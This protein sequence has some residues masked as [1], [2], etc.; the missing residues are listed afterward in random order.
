MS[1]ERDA[2]SM[3]PQGKFSRYRSVRQPPA[4]AYPPPVEVMPDNSNAMG[5]TKSMSRYRRSRIGSPELSNDTPPPLPA[6]PGGNQ[7][8]FAVSSGNQRVRRV[9]DPASSATR[10]QPSHPVERG[11]LKS[12][13]AGHKETEDER[14]RRKVKEFREREARNARAE[15]QKASDDGQFARRKNQAAQIAKQRKAE[16]EAQAE[17]IRAQEE[18]T[19]RLLAEQKRKDLERLEATLDAAGPRPPSVTSPKDKFNFFSRKRATSKVAPPRTSRS[20]S[21]SGSGTLSATRTRSIEAPPK[22]LK[23]AR[24]ASPPSR[25]VVREPHRLDQP[26]APEQMIQEGGGGIVPQTD[27]PISASN[28][29]ERRV[30][31]RCKQSSINLPVTPETTPVDLIYSAANIMTQNIIPS[32]AIILESYK[33]LGLERRIRRYEHIRDVMNSWD[34]DTQNSLTIANSE[35]PQFDKDLKAEFAPKEA[36]N[37]TTVYMYHSQKPGKWNKRYITLLPSGQIHMSK[38]TPEKSSDK[39]ILSLCHLSDFDIY[40]STPS[41]T[42]KV[43]KPPKKFCYAIKSQEKT[44]MFLSTENFVHYFSTDDETLSNKWYDAVQGWRSWYLTSRMDIKKKKKIVQTKQISRTHAVKVSVDEDPYTIGTFA[45]LLDMDRF[46]DSKPNRESLDRDYASDGGSQ[47]RQVPFHLRN[48]VSLSPLPSRTASKRHPPNS[49]RAPPGEEEFSSGGL[50]GRTYSQRQKAQKEREITGHDSGAFVDG[51]S[52][53]N[54]PV[55]T[56]PERTM[57]MKSTKLPADALPKPLLDF[58]PVFKEAPQWDRKGKGRGVKPTAG[59]PLVNVATTP[60]DV[61]MMLNMQPGQT[62]FRR[63]QEAPVTGR[64]KTAVRPKTAKEREGPFVGGGLVMGA[65][66][67]RTRGE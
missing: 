17:K 55:T 56:R 9:T 18:E 23:K 27:A 34:R 6:M 28:A 19:A 61:N 46:D 16:A 14:L 51:P 29:G 63:D 22:E 67:V 2:P 8:P 39:D 38:K 37:A 3:T 15:E 21:G 5:R 4:K 53:L 48:S 24:N 13:V 7:D 30:L 58:A 41:Q 40:S 33:Q 32:S 20:G 49:Y 11:G 44:T 59:M 62:L 47:P 42:R 50:L 64:P 10:Q 12:G 36:P 57:S 66:M 31:I 43:L 65:G 1:E 54:H 45:P 60:E 52:L 26:L 25:R 35:N